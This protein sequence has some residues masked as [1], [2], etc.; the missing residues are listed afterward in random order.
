M[1][2]TPGLRE[3]TFKSVLS[4]KT[5]G[6]HLPH[7]QKPQAHTSLTWASHYPAG[8]AGGGPMQPLQCK[9]GR[10]L[11]PTVMG[12]ETGSTRAA[13]LSALVL[14]TSE[15]GDTESARQAAA[16]S[17]RASG[18]GLSSCPAQATPAAAGTQGIPG[19]REDGSLLQR[20][21]GP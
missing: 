10:G 16:Q 8:R 17:G 5:R 11:H 3:E 4:S 12:T 14:P 2:M 6:G 21:P 13:I 15:T 19:P 20:W 1:F 9:A 18:V 7:H